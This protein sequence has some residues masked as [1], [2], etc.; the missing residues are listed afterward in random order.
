MKVYGWAWP[1]SKRSSPLLSAEAPFKRLGSSQRRTERGRY[2][3]RNQLSVRQQPAASSCRSQP[4]SIL[5]RPIASSLPYRS[6]RCS[7][8]PSPRRM[9]DMSG[10]KSR[11]RTMTR[12]RVNA[13]SII[14]NSFLFPYF[15]AF[16]PRGCVYFSAFGKRARKDEGK[17][18]TENTLPHGR[19]IVRLPCLEVWLDASLGELRFA[20]WIYANTR[21]RMNGESASCQ[22]KKDAAGD[23]TTIL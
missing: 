20:E 19:K 21:G 18:E 4:S 6:L 9:A 16:R 5:C 11:Q 1:I 22:K 10:L 8:L 17:P 15:Q 12:T 14:S 13:S 23:D 3:F 2:C 7:E